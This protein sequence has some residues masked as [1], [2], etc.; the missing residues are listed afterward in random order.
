MTQKH[1][2][3]IGVN[4]YPN[5]GEEYRLWGCVNDA[6]LVGQVLQDRFGFPA[7]NVTLLL[8]EQATQVGI[9][10]AFDALTRRVGEDDIVVFHF[11][12][13]GSRRPS[14]DP[15]EATGK[16]S[17]IMP[18]D[19]GRRPL[20]NLDIPDKEINGWLETLTA[21]THNVTMI[22]DCCHS[23]TIT[24][25]AFGDRTRSVPDDDRSLE[26]LGLKPEPVDESTRGAATA[27]A[28][29]FM[30]LG[31]KYVVLS[32]C[33]DDELAR[34]FKI[35]RGEDVFLTGALTHYLIE[36]LTGAR[37]GTTY[38]DVFEVVR[39]RIQAR[40]D[41]QHPQ[42]SGTQD[43]E[44]FGVRD[45][46][47]IRFVSVSEVEGERVTL[48]GGAAHGLHPESTWRVYP[49]GTKAIDE[50]WAAIVRIEHVAA[51]T[52]EG[53]VVERRSDV[54]VDGRCVEHGPAAAQFVLNVALP[55][56]ATNA[57]LRERID[58][59]ALLA[60]SEPDGADY[61]VYALEPRDTATADDALPQRPVI[62]EP[63]YALVSGEGVLAMPLVP[64]ADD[65][66]AQRVADNLVTLARYRNALLLDNP[67]SALDVEFNIYR[68]AADDEWELANG[69]DAQFKSGDC[70]SFEFVNNE[71]FPVFF[72]LFNFGM[73]GRVKL[74]YPRQSGGELLPAGRRVALARGDN[75]FRLSVPDEFDGDEG[76]DTYKVFFTPVATDFQWL[77]QSGTRSTGAQSRLDA[78]F[79]AAY[80]GPTTRDGGFD[81]PVDDAS[82]QNDW[83]AVG[84]GLRL[85]R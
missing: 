19:S 23:G 68:E 44:V 36:A 64:R 9:R 34:E 31:N 40:Y 61:C 63:V 46:E 17:T 2:L 37:T 62:D 7:E 38:R 48:A 76:V 49:P 11:S 8:D 43:K 3:L 27:R 24:R 5:L 13:H 50:H 82:S 6:R 32:A 84:R 77:E 47:P 56:A 53:V 12:G 45:I 83:R 67:Q 33:R 35:K 10:S 15:S 29:G 78:L 55:D 25:D 85:R 60:A 18:H 75:R 81:T 71:T 26:E 16:D 54:E 72:N 73:T 21:K 52:S 22:F 79:R 4:Q 42:L 41:T 39:Q 51:L 65:G 58:A 30:A 20:P 80:A 1:A 74:I 28:G 57:A 59:N 14:T 70:L 66:A 69:G